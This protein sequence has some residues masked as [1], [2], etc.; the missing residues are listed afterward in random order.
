MQRRGYSKALSL[1]VRLSQGQH[2]A[3]TS[4]RTESLPA[5]A[6][7]LTSYLQHTSSWVCG[8]HQPWAAG[9][10]LSARELWYT[11]HHSAWH[12]KRTFLSKQSKQF[13]A[14]QQHSYTCSHNNSTVVAAM[15]LC[16]LSSWLSPAVPAA[17]GTTRATQRSPS[18][19]AAAMAA[20]QQHQQQQC[21]PPVE[22]YSRQ[23]Q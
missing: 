17:A 5:A 18:H 19:K 7:L 8:W 10:A 1:A 16:R 12:S 23:Q 21:T 22:Q 13:R 15:P 11:A 14:I 3:C 4:A 9:G 2:T 6:P 20:V